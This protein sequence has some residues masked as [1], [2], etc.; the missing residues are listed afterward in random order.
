MD[1]AFLQSLLLIVDSGSIAQA[2]RTQHLTGAA[3]RQRVTAL[4][5]ELNTALL[6]RKGHICTPTQACIDLLPRARHLV[7]E[8]ALLKEDIDPNTLS[9]QLRIG[10]I[11]TAL[12]GLIP[13][14]LRS[15]SVQAPKVTPFLKPGSSAFLYDDLL[16]GELDA[17][18]TVAP[19]FK[20]PK[21]IVS[22]KLRSEKLLFI[23]QVPSSSQT[24]QQQ[25]AN[26]P[27]IRY[28]STSWGG[29]LTQQYILDQGMTTKLLCDLDGLEAITLMVAE[30]L[31]VSLIPHWLGLDNFVNRLQITQIQAIKY[32]RDIV[33]LTTQSAAKAEKIKFLSALLL[34]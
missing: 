22:T 15:L 20:L 31:G 24:I 9:G 4:E 30:G 8:G 26:R 19:P 1:L 29:Q 16:N 28:D 32:K 13:K 3:L 18:I 10:A 2:A 27:Y 5:S 6:V 34:E 11:S 21:S 17:V 33:L 14:A 25:L 12:T 7:R 23:S